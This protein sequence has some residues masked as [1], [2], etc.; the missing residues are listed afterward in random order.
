MFTPRMHFE[1]VTQEGLLIMR[2]SRYSDIPNGLDSPLNH[3]VAKRDADTL[4][5]VRNAIE[6]KQTLLA[7]QGIMVAHEP[8]RVGF[9]E[10]LIRIL[11]ETGRIIPAKDFINQV[12]KT[13][14]GREI[15]RLALRMG[16]QTLHENP[17]IRVSVNMSARSIGYRPWMQ[18]LNNWLSKDE[19]LAERLILEIT[20]SSAMDQPEITKD[21]MKHVSSH[22]V[23]FALDDFGAGYTSLSYLKDFYFDILKIDSRFCH[24]IA[25]DADN[26]ALVQVMISIAR[27]FDMLTVAEGVERK[28]DVETLVAL[29]ADCLQGFY[30]DAPTTRPHWAFGEQRRSK[31]KTTA[32]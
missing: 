12:E 28:E 11:D 32:A 21:F 4:Q 9:Y 17:A 5:M 27:H 6:H 30:F 8:G 20:E 15:D 7:Y 14:T 26:Q 19:T 24:G 25:E 16:L 18:T 13:K 23:C 22:G 29:G 31:R 3:A 10:G 2:K 1:T